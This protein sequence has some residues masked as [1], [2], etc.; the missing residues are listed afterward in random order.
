MNEDGS[1]IANGVNDQVEVYGPGSSVPTWS[2]TIPYYARGIQIRNDGLQ[3]FV[4]AVNLAT[5]DS[6]FVYCFNVGDD[7]PLWTRSFVGNYTAFVLSKSANRL[8][9]GEY[10]GGNVNYLF[11][12]QLIGDL[13]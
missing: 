4:V 5:Q 3:V 7:N 13:I 2:T 6:S 1:F 8:L 9:L 12:I 10:G 11:L